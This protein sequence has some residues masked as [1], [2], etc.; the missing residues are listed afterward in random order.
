MTFL[1]ISRVDG[2]VAVQ[3]WQKDGFESSP[4]IISTANLRIP[5]FFICGC[6]LKTLISFLFDE[7]RFHAS[8]WRS[9]RNN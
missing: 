5:I 9:D 6:L 7:P 3:T 2:Q 1:S 8:I 4:V